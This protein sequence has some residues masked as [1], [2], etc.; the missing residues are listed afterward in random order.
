M[1]F[2]LDD[3]R[4]AAPRVPAA[5]SRREGVLLSLVAHGAT[6]LLIIFPPFHGAALAK[7]TVVLTEP[8]VTF[9]Q[10]SPR[11]DRTAMAVRP[12]E[13]SD[14]DRR[15]TTPERPKTADNPMPFSRGETAEKTQGAP[16]EKPARSETTVA[17]PIERTAEAPAPAPTPSAA[18]LSGALRDLQRYLKDQNFDNRRGGLTDQEPDI[19]FDAKGVE[20]GPW[21]RRF[22]AQLKRNWL[23]PTNAMFE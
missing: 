8:A 11:I 21:I 13:A 23:I 18:D 12:P 6:A 1:L 10:M 15:S 22:I 14:R 5:I 19:Q 17:P 7:P 4:P 9:V 16:D 2:D 3:L 20:F